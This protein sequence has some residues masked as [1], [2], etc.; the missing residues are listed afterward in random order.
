V[1]LQ[2]LHKTRLVGCLHQ[3]IYK[4]GHYHDVYVF[5]Q[6]KEDWAKQKQHFDM[7]TIKAAF[8]DWE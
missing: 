7:T 5:E 6:L 4:N 3:H 2:K 8:D 1:K